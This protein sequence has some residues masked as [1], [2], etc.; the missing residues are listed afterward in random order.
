MSEGVSIFR[1][2]IGDILHRRFE[3]RHR[4]LLFSPPRLT[5]EACL[6]LISRPGNGQV[7]TAFSPLL[8]RQRGYSYWRK[9][10]KRARLPSKESSIPYFPKSQYSIFVESHLFF[11]LPFF[12]PRT[13]L[14]PSAALRRRDKKQNRKSPL[15]HSESSKCQKTVIESCNGVVDLADQRVFCDNEFSHENSFIASQLPKRTMPSRLQ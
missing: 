14:T 8:N 7:A 11:Y 1:R 9:S 2:N 12:S 13:T 5:N 15:F 10:E 6:R 3:P 4:S